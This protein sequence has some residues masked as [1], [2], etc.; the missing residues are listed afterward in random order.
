MVG[1]HIAWQ[2]LVCFLRSHIRNTTG[3]ALKVLNIL[4]CM[5]SFKVNLSHIVSHF[6]PKFFLFIF[7][8]ATNRKMFMVYA[9]CASVHL[10]VSTNVSRIAIHGGCWMSENAF[11]FTQSII[12]C[13]S[14]LD[15]NTRVKF[16]FASPNFY[17]V[18]TVFSA[19][20]S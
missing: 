10:V 16:I 9:R 4:L 5:V 1:M 11:L 8:I 15:C 2:S 20:S 13:F 19:V 7:S 12:A 17:I 18:S 3:V 14:T 6:K